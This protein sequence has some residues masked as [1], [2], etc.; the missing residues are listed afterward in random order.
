VPDR[1]AWPTAPAQAS[2]FEV[3]DPRTDSGMRRVEI[4][5]GAV[6]VERAIAGVKM[7]FAVPFT[8]FEGVALDV[9]TGRSGRDTRVAVRLVHEDKDLEL[10]LFEAEDDCD[11]AAE[12]QCWAK[13]LSLPLLIA[14]RD[15]SYVEPFPR[16]GALI[17][18]RPRPRRAPV[19]VRSRRPRF[20]MRRG[21]AR[22]P[23]NPLVHREQEII[24][25][26]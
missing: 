20:L 6:L 18:G 10:V 7:R 26:D 25:R 9:G 3:E 21:I 11:V 1:A 13:R 2:S 12:W 8:L 24:A 19:H 4:L 5:P 16:L 15:G 23:E 17:I 14:E 22:L